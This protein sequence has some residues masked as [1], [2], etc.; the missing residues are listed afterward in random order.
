LNIKFNCVARVATADGS[1]QVEQEVLIVGIGGQGIQLVGKTLAQAATDA[2]LH[3]M[4]AA[5]YGGE[6]RGGPSQSTVVV[7]DAPLRALPILPEAG[8]AIVMHDKFSGPAPERVR[9]D[10]LVVLNS[11]IVDPAAV[12]A[13]HR[14]VALPV[15]DMARELGAPQAAG[16]IILGAF[17]AVTDVV[18]HD[19]L[20]AAMTSL[21]PPYRKQ[22]AEA[23][24]R[25]LAAGATAVADREGAAA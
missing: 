9:P 10:G 23:N 17:A 25:A 12:P 19:R 3:A 16:L 20:V 8:A 15:T 7:G 4:L 2:G 11:S 22:H 13:T 6:M 21:L 18:D 14:V 24:A 1:S 5:E